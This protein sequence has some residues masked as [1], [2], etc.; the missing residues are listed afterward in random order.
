MPQLYMREA[1]DGQTAIEILREEMTVASPHRGFD[2]IFMDSVM[3]GRKILPPFYVTYLRYSFKC[4]ALKQLRL[5][6][7]K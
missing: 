2:I 6:E 5:C 4:M 3:V 1:D 7:I